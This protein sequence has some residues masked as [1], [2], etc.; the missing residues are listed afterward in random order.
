[1]RAGLIGPYA[2]NQAVGPEALER[3]GFARRETQHVV[4][5][6]IL[7]TNSCGLHYPG[8][9]RTAGRTFMTHRGTNLN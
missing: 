9:N 2:R 4:V 3:R 6:K 8:L 7:A 5:K 1:M